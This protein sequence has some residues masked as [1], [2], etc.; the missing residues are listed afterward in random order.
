V[1]FDSYIPPSYIEDEGSRM[2]AYRRIGAISSRKDVDDL[3][4][5]VTDRYGDPPKQFIFLTQVALIKALAGKAGF[6][7]VC[8]RDTGVLLYFANDR[9]A[10]FEQVSVLFGKPEYQG[11]IL[12]CAQG[13]P[14]LHYKPRDNNRAR[15]AQ[16]AVDILNLLIKE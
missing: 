5:E 9:K 13:K 2:A 8:I 3:I 6:E 15:T 14:Y 1:D 4:D 12:F 7:R 10:D 11:R 16:D